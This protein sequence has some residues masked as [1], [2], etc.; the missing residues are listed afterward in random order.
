MDD[1]FARSAAAATYLA[2]RL[3]RLFILIVIVAWTVML[4]WWPWAQVAPLGHPYV[5]MK[6]TANFEWPND[7]VF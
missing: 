6:T 2:V 1:G 7:G 4:M 5:A 3:A